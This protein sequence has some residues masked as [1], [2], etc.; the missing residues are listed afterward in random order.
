MYVQ[1]SISFSRKLNLTFNFWAMKHTTVN[2]ESAAILE[3]M[4]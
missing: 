4:Q 1:V 3:E 2:H